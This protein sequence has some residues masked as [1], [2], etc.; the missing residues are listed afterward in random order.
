M[1][2]EEQILREEHYKQGKLYI[3]DRAQRIIDG[4]KLLKRIEKRDKS[5]PFGAENLNLIKD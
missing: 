4:E 1:T 3:K 2:E 5:L